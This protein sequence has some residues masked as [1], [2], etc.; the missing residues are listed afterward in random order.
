MNNMNE[1]KKILES[2]DRR[3][4]P[5][6]KVTKGD[7]EFNGYILHI[8]HVQG[9]PF[10]SPSHLTIEVP[11]SKA[12]F[13]KEFRTEK[14]RRIA[15][16]DKLLRQFCL[17][18][19]KINRIAKGSGKSG[20]IEV[21]RPGQEILERSDCR[22]DPVTG[23]VY[24]RFRAGFPANGRTI[25]SRELIKML[26]DLIPECVNK[27]LFFRKETE[28]DIQEVIELS[29][30]QWEIRRQMKEQGIIAFIADGAVLPRSSGISQKPMKDAVLF[31]SPETLK[32]KIETVHRGIITGMGIRRGVS[33][34]VGGGYHGKST[35][36]KALERGVYDH[37]S[38]DGR[39]FV[40]TDPCAVK[41]RAEDG[42][43][44]HGVDISMFINNLPDGRDT[45]DFSTEDASGSTSQAANVA[46]ALEAG[47]KTLLIDEDTCATNFMIRD[48]LMQKVISRD[49]EPITPFIS[50]IEQL[51]NA[52]ISIILVAGSSGDFF[53]VSDVVIQM[54][55]YNAHDITERA[56][57]A[58]SGLQRTKTEIL[59]CQLPSR[60]RIPEKPGKS[61]SGE[62]IK[63]RTMG[64]DGFSINHETVSLRYVEQIVDTGQN[65]ALCRALILAAGKMIDGRKTLTEIVE[66]TVLL[67]ENGGPDALFYGRNP[68][69]GLAKPRKQ[70]IF[71][72]FN[73]IRSLAVNN[74]QPS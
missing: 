41:I 23:T 56:R 25:N 18:T 44:V 45:S 8:D 11:G 38:G 2:I 73:R 9:D 7:Y 46:E 69:A 53:S 63:T 27:A 58:V 4:Y 39:E 34:I 12:G 33:L 32:I 37:I 51:K 14:N 68:E 64:L 22:I 3:S 66:E 57:N 26:F 15:L 47:A 1:L 42:R 62:R 31:R 40:F 19:E 59:P 30:D 10:A 16:Q 61:L 49:D 5:H 6:Y 67:M 54:E 36:L 50:R 28:K 55:R 74:R 70:E 29:D 35:L 65:A 60:Q 43:S 52:G 21:C 13:P 17:E 24:M 48:D 20:I 71:A 72:C